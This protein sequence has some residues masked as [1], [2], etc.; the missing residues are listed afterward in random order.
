MFRSRAPKAAQGGAPPL[1]GTDPVSVARVCTLK[2]AAGPPLPPMPATPPTNGLPS[3]CHAADPP[4]A[5]NGAPHRPLVNGHS[6]PKLA[7]PE[8]LCIT[9]SPRTSSPDSLRCASPKAKRPRRSRDE[10]HSASVPCESIP[11]VPRENGTHSIDAD[12]RESPMAN[13]HKEAHAADAE[14]QSNEQSSVGDSSSSSAVLPRSSHSR[15]TPSHSEVGST[16][17]RR[18]RRTPQRTPTPTHSFR[19]SPP[20]A[21]PGL[22]IPS[23]G[24]V[25]TTLQDPPTNPLPAGVAAMCGGKDGAGPPRWVR[26]MDHLRLRDNRWLYY[27][28]YAGIDRRFDEWAEQDRIE[29]STATVDPPVELEEGPLLAR[30]ALDRRFSEILQ[31]SEKHMQYHPKEYE[32]SLVTKMKT[33]DSVRYGAYDIDCWY[34]SPYPVHPEHSGR[35]LFVCEYCMKYLITPSALERHYAQCRYRHPPGDEIYRDPSRGISVFEVVGRNDRLYC[36]NLCLFAKLFLD[37]KTMHYDVQHFL[38][39]ILCELEPG[40]LGFR[41]VGYFSKEK[42][43]HYNLACLLI[44]PPYQRN[45]YGRFLIELSYEL[46]RK[47]GRPGTP[48][49]PLSDLGRVSYFSY[50]KECLLGELVGREGQVCTIRSLSLATAI[51]PDDVLHTL[52]ALNCIH[53]VDGG[54]V[55]MI[56]VPQRVRE[57]HLRQARVS[58]LR[59]ERARLHY[60]P[61]TTPRRVEKDRGV[62]A[63]G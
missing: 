13:G 63:K 32:Q 30:G 34:F 20:P 15:R 40:G 9:G 55:T 51:R 5:P 57:D 54:T 18:G 8:G 31:R 21:L 10:F 19:P 28:H 60:C 17:T 50:W 33:V 7:S 58:R 23:P 1:Q 46:S 42:V 43:D 48:E 52:H 16:D 39:Y 25:P 35:H 36:Q 27:V 41:M 29:L 61:A 56:K 45:G 38:F 14:A 37:H 59:L 2:Q 24:E 12:T 47:E 3:L 49:R 26:I 4:L 53:S 62:E 11:E 22:S 44:V 6:Y